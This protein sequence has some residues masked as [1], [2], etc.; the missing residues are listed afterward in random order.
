[1]LDTFFLGHLLYNKQPSPFGVQDLSKAWWARKAWPAWLDLLDDGEDILMA[2]NF[3]YLLRTP[4]STCGIS[5]RL[6]ADIFK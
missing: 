5:Q 4:N 1:M 2:M 3:I 6:G